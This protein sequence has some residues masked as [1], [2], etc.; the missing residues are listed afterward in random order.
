MIQKLRNENNATK[1]LDNISFE[2]IEEQFLKINEKPKQENKKI[3]NNSDI[4]L[5]I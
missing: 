1:Y 4:Y 2:K 5:D 3:N